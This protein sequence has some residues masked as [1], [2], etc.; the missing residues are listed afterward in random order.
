MGQLIQTRVHD[1]YIEEHT[2]HHSRAVQVGGLLCDLR[3]SR[4]EIW[5]E[6]AKAQGLGNSGTYANIMYNYLHSKVFMAVKE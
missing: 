1:R 5:Y 4:G 6:L 3:L 2:K